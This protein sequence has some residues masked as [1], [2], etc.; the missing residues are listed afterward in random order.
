MQSTS[1]AATNAVPSPLTEK[2]SIIVP[3][4]KVLPMAVIVGS[5]DL[6]VELMDFLG[7]YRI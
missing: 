6:L 3:D 5:S 1:S 7:K 2:K 4:N